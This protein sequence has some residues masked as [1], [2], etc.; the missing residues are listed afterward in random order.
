MAQFDPRGT[1]QSISV[2][3]SLKC[4]ILITHVRKRVFWGAAM[5][6]MRTLFALLAILAFS[7]C[8]S[9]KSDW[10]EHR[11]EARRNAKPF[12]LGDYLGGIMEYN[13]ARLTQSE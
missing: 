6:R 9:L 12:D 5:A 11:R 4:L 7:G 8:A 1:L 3:T 13:M 2:D 10:K